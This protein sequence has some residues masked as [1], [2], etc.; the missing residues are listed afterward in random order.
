M[1][2]S[3][4]ARARLAATIIFTLA[5][6]PLSS[7]RAQEGSGPST[8]QA[9]A[10]SLGLT[11]GTAAAGGLLLGLGDQAGDYRTASERTGATLLGLGLV[12][13][14]AAGDLYTGQIGRAATFSL[15]RGALMTGAV[16]LVRDGVRFG[17]QRGIYM[18]STSEAWA[19]GLGSAALGLAAWEIATTRGSARPPRPPRFALAPLA[20]G[21]CAIAT[22]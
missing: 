20:A 16:L 17:S 8:G 9:L 11:A 12:L 10:L 22:F 19:L 2:M 4:R 6:T 7:A 21:V 3:L 13:G 1:A 5:V 15:A 14:P 18:D